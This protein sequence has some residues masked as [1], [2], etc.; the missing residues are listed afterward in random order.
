MSKKAYKTY[1]DTRNYKAN[2]VKDYNFNKSYENAKKGN[3]Q[4]F[5]NNAG[6]VFRLMLLI[7]IG[8]LF[9][10]VFWVLRGSSNTVN[11]TGF[12]EFLSNLNSVDVSISVADFSIGGDW[13]VFEF[14]RNF[15]NIFAQLF[16]VIVW[17]FSNIVNLINYLWQFVLF[18]FS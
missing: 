6:I 15:F 2:Y 1:R 3:R 13:G 5:F 8:I 12:L 7:F 9:L 10:R 18:L 14:L 17:L 11:F 16:G 4:H